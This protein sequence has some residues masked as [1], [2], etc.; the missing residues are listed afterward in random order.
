VFNTVQ[1]TN[2]KWQSKEIKLSLCLT[3]HQAIKM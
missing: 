3:K 1:T 2:D